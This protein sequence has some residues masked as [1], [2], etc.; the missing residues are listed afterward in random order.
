MLAVHSLSFSYLEKTILH[1]IS[2][3][4]N[5]GQAIAIMGESGSGKSTLL[6]L[7]YGL[8]DA[9]AG[10]ILWKKERI[11][12][13]KFHLVPGMPFM[14]YLAQDFDLMPFTTAAENVG[15]F[16]SNFYLTHKA[17]RITELLRVVGMEEYAG[18]KTKY[19]SGGQ[20]QR[21]A[22][23]RAL[24][25]EPEVLLL[26]EPFTHIDTHL[27]RQL[28]RELFAYCK[29]K[30]IT[31]LFVTHQP[32][33]G[34]QFADEILVI[35]NGRL[36]TKGA[37]EKLY[38]AS[39]DLYTA[40]L[41]GE[42]NVLPASWFGENTDKELLLRPHQ[43]KMSEKGLPCTFKKAYYSGTNYLVAVVFEGKTIYFEHPVLPEAAVIYLALAV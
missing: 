4:V 42:I 28:S 11:S 31:V 21:V 35:R 7:L 24:A 43:L 36:I 16:L 1:T 33:E 40:R 5:E 9:E 10:E 32:E 19:L 27:K 38:N 34:L 15:H 22:L 30:N 20:M 6:K 13:P 23:A 39:T 12:G 8:Y 29:Q 2:F 41:L 14:K 26:D 25:L 17:E 37:P 3:S 18:I